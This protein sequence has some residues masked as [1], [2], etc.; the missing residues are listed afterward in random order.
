MRMIRIFAVIACLII[1]AGCTPTMQSQQERKLQIVATL[2]PQ[3][4]FAREIAGDYAQVSLLLPPG[5]ESHTFEPTPADVIK[6]G[7]ADLFIYTGEGMEPWA[8]SLLDG[9]EGDVQVLDIS[10]NVMMEEIS[11]EKEHTQG[12]HHEHSGG[13][14]HI[15]TSPANAMIMVE[16]L[17]NQLCE[18]DPVH[19]KI[20][21][22]NAD[23]YQANLKKL[24]ERF[25]Q[26][27]AQAPHKEIIFGGRF[28]LYYFAKR[29]G[30]EYYAAFD[31]CSGET[32]PSAGAVA[33]IIDEMQKKGLSTV[34]YEEMVEPKVA[35]AIAQE[36]GA[37]ILLLHSCHNVSP[38]E[39]EA[40]ES[41]LSLME[42]NAINLEKG[43]K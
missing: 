11:E 32:E 36:T 18:L 6:I 8:H 40:G 39:L 5:V 12:H 14:P 15:W 29:Y 23:E 16:N 24:D 20:F 31:S 35:R 30:L 7:N 9:I 41:Y 3:Y 28:A 2:F 34:F 25:A 17:T 22:Q 43:L 13:D 26:I 10:E 42:Q 21:R 4:D 19:A 27:V 37:Q 1:L 33:G 38:A